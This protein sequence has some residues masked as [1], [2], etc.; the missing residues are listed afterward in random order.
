MH[1]RLD[2]AWRSIRGRSAYPEAVAGLL[3]E[4]S[5]AA[6]LFTG[7]VKVDG[8][9]SIQLRGSGALRTV[10]AECTSAGSLRGLARFE[11]PLPE[12]LDPRHFGA[13]AMLAITIESSLGENREPQRYQGLVGLD[14]DSLATAFEDYFGQSE[15]LPTRILLAADGEQACG[16]ILQQLPGASDDADAWPRARPCSTPSAATSCWRY[17]LKPCSTACSTRKACA[18][19][20]RSRCASAAPARARGSAAC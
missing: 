5:A 15:Q 6:A 2:E 10:F 12:P 16:L 1:V 4:A 17:P 20:R 14:A 3:G 19:W 11:A 13:D 7:H 8:R 18:W 9:L